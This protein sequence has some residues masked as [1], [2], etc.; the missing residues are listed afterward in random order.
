MLTS[1]FVQRNWKKTRISVGSDDSPLE[2]PK[3]KLRLQR[4]GDSGR[5]TFYQDDVAKWIRN[6]HI[7]VRH[8]GRTYLY[9]LNSFTL[10]PSLYD[11]AESYNP[12]VQTIS[13]VIPKVKIQ[14]R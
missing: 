13:T 11:I 4:L 9:G 3:Y 8:V 14:R 5:D 10:T 2:R 6:G 1:T 12:G 7:T